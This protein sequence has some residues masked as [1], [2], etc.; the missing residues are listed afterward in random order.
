MY[1]FP[2]SV[3]DVLSFCGE[4]PVPLDDKGT[5]LVDDAGGCVHDP[6]NLSARRPTTSKH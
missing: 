4:L 6:F 1:D 5:A 3:L 2:A